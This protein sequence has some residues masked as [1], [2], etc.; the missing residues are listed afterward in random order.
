MYKVLV[1]D[2]HPPIRQVVKISLADI[3]ITG[4][5]ECGN[6]ADAIAMLKQTPYDLVILDIGIPKSDGM[7]VIGNIKKAELATRVLIFTSQSIELYGPRCMALGASGFVSKSEALE[8]LL[9]AVK[10]ISRGY[11]YFPELRMNN[12]NSQGQKKT[13]TNRELDVL[14]LLA[15]GKSNNDI[16][17]ELS[18]SCKTIST[19][20]TRMMEKLGA[21]SFVELLS[22]AKRDN[23]V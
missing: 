9:A 16:A 18:L 11:K 22:I 10:A 20:K 19:Y 4:V 17:M 13:L 21:G 1:V 12:L 23:L 2:D 6:G 5:D 8:D 3:G 14:R 7:A 15:S